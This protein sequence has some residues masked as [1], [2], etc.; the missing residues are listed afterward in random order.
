MDALSH[1]LYGGIVFGRRSWSSFKLSFFFGMA[2]DLFSFGLFFVLTLVGVIEHPSWFS[3][4]HPA[5]EAIPGYIHSLYAGTH[6]L[7]VFACVFMVVWLVRKKPFIEM[8]GW[9]L[10]ILVDI[11]THAITDFATPFLWP[12]SDWRFDGWN[13]DHP[14]I[15]I[16]NGVLLIG[17]YTWFFIFRWRQ[18]Y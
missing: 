16:S 3:G 18:K 2:P 8:L 13:W 12:L 4:E 14:A 11:P 10:H 9:P 1:A 15:F 7:V 17:L 5:P 6:S